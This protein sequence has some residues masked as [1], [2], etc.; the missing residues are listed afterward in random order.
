MARHG[1]FAEWTFTLGGDGRRWDEDFA[2]LEKF[3]N[4]TLQRGFV[5]QN[6]IKALHDTHG[7]FLVP[8]RADTQGVSRDEAMSSGLVPVTTALESISEFV[9]SECGMLCAP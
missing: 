9:D 4:V 8:S 6:E 1:E 7:V 2:G 5:S 3:P